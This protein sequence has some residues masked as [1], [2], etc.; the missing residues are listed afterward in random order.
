MKL[1]QYREIEEAYAHATNGGQA[2]HMGGNAARYPGAPDASA[3]PAPLL[4]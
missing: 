4:T 2:L 3:G 1:F